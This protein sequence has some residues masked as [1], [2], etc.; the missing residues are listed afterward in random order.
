MLKPPICRFEH[1]VAHCLDLLY[2]TPYGLV[3]IPTKPE[4]QGLFR[5]HLL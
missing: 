5:L 1:I 4:A 3:G 2:R